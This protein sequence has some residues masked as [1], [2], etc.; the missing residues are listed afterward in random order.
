MTKSVKMRL[1]EIKRGGNSVSYDRDNSDDLE[2]YYAE[3][4]N[5]DNTISLMALVH[6]ITGLLTI[7]L[8]YN[9]ITSDI[10]QAPV[11]ITVIAIIQGS[12]LVFSVPVWFVIGWAI[13]SLQPWVWK[14]AV[15]VNVVFLFFNII[16]GIIL[17]AI[18]NIV[19]LFALYGSD[20]RLALT[21]IDTR[22][23]SNPV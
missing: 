9:I 11:I 1:W 13:W 15:I 5:I 4:D 16:G 10:F 19:L 12:I 7:P 8:I 23:H 14:V 6:I 20:V 3:V 18:M 17:I 2:S 22:V 21:P